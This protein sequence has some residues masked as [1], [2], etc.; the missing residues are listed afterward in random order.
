[1]PFLPTTLF[2]SV[3]QG[4]TL[5]MLTIA[6]DKVAERLDA[7]PSRSTIKVFGIYNNTRNEDGHEINV[8]DFSVVSKPKSK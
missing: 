3:G 5:R 7:V 6:F 2:V 1:M 8:T 4:R